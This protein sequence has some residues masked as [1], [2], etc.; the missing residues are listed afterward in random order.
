MQKF[1]KFICKNKTLVL[2]ITSILFLLSLVGMSLTKINYNILL[3]LPED[4]ETVKGQNILTDNFNMGAF[5]IVVTDDMNPKEILK[6]EKTI[7]K[8]DGVN[9]VASLYDVIGTDIPKEI[10]PSEIIDKVSKGESDLLIVTFNDSTSDETTLNAIKELRS[11]E[12]RS[13][14]VSGM[15]S[16]VLDTMELSEKEITVYIVIAVALCLLIL[17]LALDSYIVPVLLLANIG[18]AVILNLGS[19]IIFGNISY[20]TK[21]LVAVLQLGVTTD[22]SI[23]LYHAYMNYRKTEKNNDE[24][25]VK[26][27]KSTF[28]SVS[29]SSITTIAGFLVLCTMK[30][31]LGTD[32]GLVMAK[33]VFLGV[34]SV[35]TIFPSL[36]LFFSN[37]IDKTAHRCLVPKFNSLNKF[38]INHQAILLVVFIILFIPAYLGYKQVEVYYKMDE[39]LPSTLE[40]I[41]SNKEIKENFNIVS[42]EI[43]LVNK[44]IKT[45]TLKKL[46]KEIESV[47]GIDLVLSEDKLSDL[48]LNKEYLSDELLSIME[49]D[50]YQLILVNSMYDIATDELNN[51]ITTIDKII[52]NYD[53]KAILAGEGPLMKD[54]ISIS[55]QDF[56]NVN[57]SSIICILLIMLFTLKSISLPILLIT[58]IEFAIFMNMSLSYFSGS[59]LPFV[60]P[61]VLGTIQLGATIDYAIL[62]TTNYL[63]NKKD[64]L[65]KKEAMLKACN[66]STNSTI[67]SGLCFFAATFGVGIYSHLEMVGSLCFL[68]SR[69]AI[70]SMFSVILFLPT[71]LLTFDKLITKTTILKTKERKFMKKKLILPMLLA[72]T[73][74][75]PVNALTKNETV[76]SKLDETGKVKNTIVTEQ[77]VNNNK[78][79][80]V[81]DISNLENIINLSNEEKININNNILTLNT[82]G[83]NIAYQG[84]INKQ[85]PITIKLTYKLDGK[86]ISLDKALGKKGHIEII[87]NYYNN[88]LKYVNIS[89]K[90]ES[91]YTPFVVAT[92]LILPEE[93]NS[94]IKITNGKIINNGINNILLGITSPGLEESLKLSNLTPLNKITISYDTEKFELPTIYN[95]AT[96]NLLNESDLSILNELTSIEDKAAMLQNGIDQIESGSEKLLAGTKQIND[97]T[98]SIYTNV[99]YINNII[100]EVKNGNIDKIDGLIQTLEKLQSIK[101]YLNN[102]NNDESLANIIDLLEKTK[103]MIDSIKKIND[104]L[105]AE[106]YQNNLDSYTYD[107]VLEMDPTKNLYNIKYNFETNY[108]NNQ[109]LIELLSNNLKT[110][111]QNKD[112][113]T[114]IYN[115]VEELIKAIKPVVEAL[116]REIA[117]IDTT[118]ENIYNDLN[119]IDALTYEFYNGTTK[120]YNGADELNKGIHKYNEEGIKVL[121]NLIN[122][123]V[124]PASAR[125]EK[126]LELGNDYQTFTMKNNDTDGTT[127]FI[128]VIDGQ[129]A[130]EKTVKTTNTTKEKTN[131]F[132]RIKNLF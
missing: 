25:M 117:N 80:S 44:D 57:Y 10:L 100:N 61:I 67:V 127:K 79:K 29:A 125:L 27:I 81:N 33:G 69:G 121:T 89:G 72:F 88:E 5:S 54:L 106:Y 113:L 38:I 28:T 130:K 86:E 58:T 108:K 35:L 82:N 75:T 40:S 93:G 15:S 103:N 65:E 9:K 1:G 60:A 49:S 39:T 12:N 124:A 83:N 85:L 7:K 78:D 37:A 21:A 16:M 122:T 95:I 99:H 126:L 50:K 118:K 101:D 74:I 48:G 31:T 107:E 116:K 3:Y 112:V 63:S 102:A 53:N 110:L 70:I 13:Y 92:S 84:I 41:K 128:M 76:Y 34:I 66:N 52:K 23:F 98:G 97:I 68:I 22:F 114:E 18:I 11:I 51:Q 87:I 109:E 55:N 123:E 91:M 96:S 71:I 111:E 45:D 8:I 32:L 90:N 120:V 94:N 2:I 36:L 46:T 47:E 77:I 4:I 129:K 131:L 56:I 42:P 24:A 59:I 30:L 73:F 104:N 119:Q 62:L 6:L 132:T 17:E 105:F 14:S 115:N 64:G 19:N 20:I 26:A 43:I